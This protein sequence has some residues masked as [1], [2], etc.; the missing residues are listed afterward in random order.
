MVLAY[1]SDFDEYKCL[2]EP[3]KVKKT[4]IWQ[5]ALLLRIGKITARFFSVILAVLLVLVIAIL[6]TIWILVRGPSPSVQRLFVMTVKETSAGGFLADIFL[7]EEEIANIYLQASNKDDGYEDLDLSL[8]TVSDN[9]TSRPTDLGVSQ[10]A[11][12]ESGSYPQQAIDQEEYDSG[13][14]LH[15]IKHNR[16][17]GYLMIVRDPK[18]VFVGT[19]DRYGSRSGATLID[20]VRAHGAIAGINGG[21]FYDPDGRGN[22][23]TPEGLVIANGEIL[24]NTRSEI[25]PRHNTVIG[26]DADGILHI[27]NITAEEAMQKGIQW[28]TTFGPVMILNSEIVAGASGANPRTAIGQRADGA[29][30]LLVVEGRQVD[31]IGATVREMAE[32]LLNYGAVNA[33]N[34]DGGSSTMLIYNDVMMIKSASP[35]VMRPLPTTILVRP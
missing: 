31:K 20:H 21:G 7:S 12:D 24:W 32:I 3:E 5:T 17:S 8:I 2:G 13:I 1:G 4:V 34:L 10:D 6:V 15:E 23:G 35:A 9:R 25:A 16:F 33:A 28:A 30:L 19:L 29:V 14:E 27:G 22:G 11:K 18:R 26:F